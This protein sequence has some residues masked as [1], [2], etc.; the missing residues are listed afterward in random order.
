MVDVRT[1]E[2]VDIVNLMSISKYLAHKDDAAWMRNYIDKQLAKRRTNEVKDLEERYQ[3]VVRKSKGRL[4][5]AT[6]RQMALADHKQH[7][8]H[9]IPA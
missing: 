2:E 7:F 9:P 8:G 4:S 3:R 1:N 6:M 5:E